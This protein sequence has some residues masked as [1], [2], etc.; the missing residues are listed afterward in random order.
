MSGD[1]VY[2][3]GSSGQTIRENI[4][5]PLKCA[6]GPDISFKHAFLLSKVCPINL[7]GRD[8]M[9]KLGLCLISTPEGVK[10]HR[11]SDLEPHFS[12]SFVHHIP[13]LQYAYLWKLQPST[14][15]EL[16]TLARKTVLTATID[17][18]TPEDLHCTSHVSPGPNEP[19]EE[20]WLRERFDKLTLSHI[21][22]T[23]HKCAISVS[24]TPAQYEVYTIDHSVPHI[25]LAKHTSDNWEDLG[26]FIKSC[27]C[28][29]D[30]QETSDRSIFFSPTL[31][32]Y[33]K[34]LPFF[35]H[36][37]RTIQL[38]PKSTFKSFSFLSKEQA[39]AITALQEVLKTLWAVSKY[40]VG[41]I[42]DCEPVVITNI[43]VKRCNVLNPATLFPTPDDGQEHNC[44]AVLQQ[45]CS[46]RPDLQETPLTNPDLVVFVDGSASRDPKTGRNRVGF[47]VV[48]NHETLASGSL[49]SHY[50]V[51]AAELTALT[52]ACK[53]ASNKT[54]TIYTDSRYAFGV[55]HDFGTLWKHRQFLKSDGKPIL[56]HDKVAALLDAILL[57]T[58]IAVCKCLAHTNN[59]DSVSLGNARA[60]TAAKRAALQ[61]TIL[62]PLFVSTPVSIPSSLTA[63]QSF[64]T[65]QEKTLW[66]RCGAT[67]EEAVWRGPDNKPCLPKHFFPHF[68][69][70]THGL[71]HVSK[72]GM[73]DA[74]TQHWFTKGFS[75]HAQK[76]C[77]SCMV[78]ATHN[79]GKTK[80]ITH[81]A[82]P[83][84]DRPFEHLMMDFI[85][86]SPAE[87]KKYCLVMVDM[88]SKWVEAFPARH[89]SSQV[90][91]KALLTEI[92]PR[93]GIPTKLS[94]DNGAHF[95]NSAITQISDFLA[96]DLRRHCAYHPASGGAVEREN[97]TLK[98]KLAKCCE[99]TG[100]PWTK[101]L[102]IV[103]MHIRMRKRSRVNMSPFEILFGRPPSLGVEPVTRPLPSTGLCDDDML[104]YCKNLSST[105]S[106]ISQQVKS[107]LPLPASTLLHDFQPGNWVVIKDFRRKHWHSK[108]WRG[109]FQVLLTTHTAVK[110]AERATWVHANHCR[111]VPEPTE[112]FSCQPERREDSRR[113][114][115]QHEDE[116]AHGEDDTR[117][118]S[119]N[120]TTTN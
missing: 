108:R 60:D 42:K 88:W 66:R 95:F 96:I 112:E 70:L 24:L 82:H 39:T 90:V 120:S 21:Y 44:V 105:L 109:P 12:H 78:C 52:E 28:A 87:G 63:M 89:Q 38:V 83:P 85:E 117:N 104:Q 19:Y 54:V 46:P 27:Q 61:P 119:I 103:L 51:Q 31:Q 56:H 110:I 5:V 102:P 13:E 94:S 107:A 26:P 93:W 34:S 55:V 69:K 40:D 86:L 68:A 99:E 57:P 17:F 91:A 59:S 76:F 48:T 9:C 25:T 4:T 116:R 114:D 118:N 32:C 81:A 49:P 11:L 43:T 15:S 98:S 3:V 30:W 74:L 77:Q 14:A 84:P 18:M 37:Q 80:T 7:M 10:V 1:Y 16:V 36:T 67:Q 62:D 111:K 8:L 92:I 75:V 58:S 72:G 20:G 45:I 100:L 33:S 29:A 71:D 2:S 6:D 101:A 53:L 97:G 106:Q 47:A 41:L 35:V 22:W 23:Q 113:G 50:S 65:P 73:L 64:A 79:S 115:G